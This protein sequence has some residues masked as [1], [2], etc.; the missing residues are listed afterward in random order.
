[1]KTNAECEALAGP[2]FVNSVLWERDEMELFLKVC[3][4]LN[5][6]DFDLQL[7]EAFWS[8]AGA[9]YV[10]CHSPTNP[11]HSVEAIAV[12]L[13]RGATESCQ[14][15]STPERSVLEE[16]TAPKHIQLIADGDRKA[17]LL[18]L[19]D[20]VIRRARDA[21]SSGSRNLTAYYNAIDPALS[22]TFHDGLVNSFHF[23]AAVLHLLDT[24]RPTNERLQSD[25]RVLARFV[26]AFAKDA[27]SA[28]DD[29]LL[30]LMHDHTH[31]SSLCAVFRTNEDES[32]AFAIAQRLVR[33]AVRLGVNWRKEKAYFDFGE[34]VAD[35]VPERTTRPRP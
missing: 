32:Y 6:N 31:V 24:V 16:P 8:A 15:Y 7:G 25:L 9:V 5:L 12:L 3:R 10:E 4:M 30:K 23:L 33:R 35:C 29:F 19:V 13:S 17:Q 27:K 11:E 18:G 1:M 34:A 14:L 28:I 21:G 20:F 22:D 26:G 2:C